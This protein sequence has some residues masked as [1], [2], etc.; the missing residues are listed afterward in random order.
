MFEYEARLPG[1]NSSGTFATDETSRRVRDDDSWVASDRAPPRLVVH[2]VRD[3]ARVVEQVAEADSSPLAKAPREQRAH[4]VVEPELALGDELHDDRGDEALRD[5][6]DPE[7]VFGARLSAADLG[8]S[9]CDDGLVA[10]LRDE[11]DHGGDVACRDEPVGGVL[12]LGL[13]GRRPTA[14]GAG[15]GESRADGESG[16]DGNSCDEP[17]VPFTRRGGRALQ[18][19]VL[20]A[21]RV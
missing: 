18:R 10:V 13:G 15:G 1:A 20:A 16:C 21:R 12:E 2:V 6:P 5:A 3:P 9:G 4:A 11:R 17:H 14:E 19:Y 8:V 7:A